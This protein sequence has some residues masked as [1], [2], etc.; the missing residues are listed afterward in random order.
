MVEYLLAN[1][2]LVL[3]VASL[4][5]LVVEYDQM[6]IIGVFLWLLSDELG[7]NLLLFLI[8]LVVLKFFLGES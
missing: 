3:I 1:L 8:L 7:A 5:K 6:E 2:L 4:Y